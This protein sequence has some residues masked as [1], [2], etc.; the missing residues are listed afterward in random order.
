M[1]KGGFSSSMVISVVV[2][3]GA[4]VLIAVLVIPVILVILAVLVIPV[5][6]SI[7]AVGLI[8]IT[9]P[10]FCCCNSTN[11]ATAVSYSHLC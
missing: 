7:A 2:A 10:I 11:A 9:T 5:A 8:A 3:A 1:A 6:V 4:T